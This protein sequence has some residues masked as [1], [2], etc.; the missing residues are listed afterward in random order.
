MTTI[1]FNTGR[2]Y[3]D[4]GQRIAA[5]RLESG[6][7]LMVDIDRGIDYLLPIGTQ[8]K[9]NEVMYSYDCGDVIY[10]LDIGMDYAD[11]YALVKNLNAAA[12]LAPSLKV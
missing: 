5:Q 7:I 9:Q 6:A 3:T 4:H 10:P 1:A 2:L 11:Y 12:Q 8:L